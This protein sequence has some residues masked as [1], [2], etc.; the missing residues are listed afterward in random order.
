MQSRDPD[1]HSRC[2]QEARRQPDHCIPELSDWKLSD[3]AEFQRARFPR[4][5]TGRKYPMLMPRRNGTGPT[6]RKWG[7]AWPFYQLPGLEKMPQEN[8]SCH[9]DGSLPHR[10]RDFVRGEGKKCRFFAPYEKGIE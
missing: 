4:A 7:A 9:L 3:P 5:F 10:L 1:S 6:D 8:E 2:L